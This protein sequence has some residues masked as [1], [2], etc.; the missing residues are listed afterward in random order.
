MQTY[1]ADGLIN[2]G[3]TG[4][5]IRFEFGTALPVVN[6]EGKQ[7]VRL[8]PTQQV[9]MPLEGFM[10][11]FGAQEQVIKK[12]IADGVIKVQHPADPDVIVS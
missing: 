12:L 5:L 1:F 4:Q 11:A 8:T 9:V 6:K 10:R 7:E 3:L 2:I